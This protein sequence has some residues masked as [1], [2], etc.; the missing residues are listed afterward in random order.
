MPLRDKNR[1]LSLGKCP[2]CYA[3]GVFR[4]DYSVFGRYLADPDEK[5]I[6]FEN[7]AANAASGVKCMIFFPACRRIFSN[8]RV[9]SVDYL[10]KNPI[11]G[12]KFFKRQKIDGT[13]LVR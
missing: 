9:G 11:F 12:F 13:M 4:K 7:R 1:A 2:G 6:G 8:V 10:W 5:Q 3:P